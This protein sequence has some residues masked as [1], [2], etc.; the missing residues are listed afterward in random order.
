MEIV[1]LRNE[2]SHRQSDRRTVRLLWA[3]IFEAGIV[4]LW[5]KAPSIQILFYH[6]LPPAELPN[7]LP[8]NPPLASPPDEL[9]NPLPPKPPLASP[10]DELP[11]P[12][13]VSNP[14]LLLW[15]LHLD[16]IMWE[17][18]IKC[19]ICF[20]Y[21]ILLHVSTFKL[22]KK[23]QKRDVSCNIFFLLMYIFPN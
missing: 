10:P 20:F 14:P 13:D 16:S 2:T 7:P 3:A 15:V 18:I 19:K 21:S 23:K 6:L 22:T 4:H 9:P 17:L 11:K 5:F 12:P 1:W 8:P